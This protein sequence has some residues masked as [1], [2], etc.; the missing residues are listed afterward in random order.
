MRAVERVIRI[1]CFSW[2][3][4]ENGRITQ[5][6]LRSNHDVSGY[7]ERLGFD[8]PV[9]E[10]F[11]CEFV[12]LFFFLNR[13][14]KRWRRR[15]RCVAMFARKSAPLSGTDWRPQKRKKFKRSNA[16]KNVF[17][18]GSPTAVPHGFR[19]FADRIFGA[20]GVFVPDNRRRR[21]YYYDDDDFDDDDDNDTNRINITAHRVTI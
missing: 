15:R 9:N 16:D 10:C 12:F 4:L 7:S 18:P 6:R 13:W 2:T 1:G 14:N 21:Y 8:C 20:L 17:T 5:R 19:I 3:G 11:F